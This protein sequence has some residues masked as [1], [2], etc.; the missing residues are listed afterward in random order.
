MRYQ[1]ESQRAK[2]RDGEE[3]RL[4]KIYIA[5]GSKSVLSLLSQVFVLFEP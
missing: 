4:Y 2:Q 3:E 5:S 1:V